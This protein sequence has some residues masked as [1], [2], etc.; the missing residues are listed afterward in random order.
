M[1]HDRA[2]K[3]PIYSVPPFSFMIRSHVT[4]TSHVFFRIPE[5]RPQQ[6]RP[7]KFYG[8]LPDTNVSRRR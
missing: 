3:S 8:F 5:K 6:K 4:R 7:V 1:S 2:R